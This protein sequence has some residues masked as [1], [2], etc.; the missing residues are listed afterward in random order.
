M[1]RLGQQGR[2]QPLVGS[3]IAV[4][5]TL[6]LVGAI[7]QDARYNC[8]S[9]RGVGAAAASRGCCHRRRRAAWRRWPCCVPTWPRRLGLESAM[10]QEFARVWVPI[11]GLVAALPAVSRFP[12][13]T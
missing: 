10:V 2:D 6:Y 4:V 11:G 8:E 7:L 13:R 12:T 1:L 3:V 5:A 9:H